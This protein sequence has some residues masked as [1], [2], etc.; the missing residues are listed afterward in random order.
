MWTF[1]VIFYALGRTSTCFPYALLRQKSIWLGTELK[2]VPRRSVMRRREEQGERGT[3]YRGDNI[4]I[5]SKLAWMNDGFQAIR[6]WRRG[7]PSNVSKPKN[8]V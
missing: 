6:V 3:G 1:L 2:D 4:E 8:L 5:S 7:V